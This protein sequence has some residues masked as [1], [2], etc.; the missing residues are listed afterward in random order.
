MMIGEW[1]TFTYIE[2]RIF[3]QFI[4]RIFRDKDK[5]SNRQYFITLR[6][7]FKYILF[8][9]CI[10]SRTTIMNLRKISILSFI[11]IKIQFNMQLV[12][13]NIC[14]TTFLQN[15][16]LT[17]WHKETIWIYYLWIFTNYV[18]KTRFEEGQTKFWY[19]KK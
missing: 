1:R 14:S 12:T 6:F 2:T 15:D 5:N 4:Q 13:L 3:R 17:E 10:V 18:K 16:N 8:N 19:S 7:W 11:C 9:W